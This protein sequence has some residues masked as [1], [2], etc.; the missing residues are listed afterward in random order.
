MNMYENY[1][2][3]AKDVKELKKLYE[4]VSYNNIRHI[5]SPHIDKYQEIQTKYD[6]AYKKILSKFEK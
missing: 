2:N 6:M 3:M 4:I 1:F 5:H